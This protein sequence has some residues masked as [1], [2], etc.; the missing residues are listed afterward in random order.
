MAFS[1]GSSLQDWRVRTEQTVRPVN[2]T[3]LPLSWLK[4]IGE[5]A[6]RPPQHVRVHQTVSKLLQGR[7]AQLQQGQASRTE[8]QIEGKTEFIINDIYNIYT[9]YR[10]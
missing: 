2:L 9:Y 8:T 7:R 6:C 5:A 10:I 3:G 1:G 4:M